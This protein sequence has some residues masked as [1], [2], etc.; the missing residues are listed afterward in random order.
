MREMYRQGDVLLVP[1]EKL[2]EGAKK[3]RRGRRGLVLAEGEATG[4][5][6]AIV[7]EGASLYELVDASDVEEMRQ[8]FLRVDQEVAVVHEEHGTVT[9]APGDY[10][11][12][13]QREYHPEKIRQVAD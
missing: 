5:A 3:V 10:E 8:R 13:I 9:P 1:I 7:D 11:V 12:R 4:H 6:H 2:P